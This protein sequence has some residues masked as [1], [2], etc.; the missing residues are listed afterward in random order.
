MTKI[1]SRI[2]VDNGVKSLN[3]HNAKNKIKKGINLV[4]PIY[5]IVKGWTKRQIQHCL[6]NI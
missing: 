2:S 6:T 3:S 1:K 4:F 5:A